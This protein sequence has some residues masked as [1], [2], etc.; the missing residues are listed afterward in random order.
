MRLQAQF[1]EATS[2]QRPFLDA[3]LRQ[4]PVLDA[5]LR[6]RSVL[7]VTSRQR[8]S[9]MPPRDCRPCSSQLPGPFRSL[10]TPLAATSISGGHFHQR[11]PPTGHMIRPPPL[12]TESQHPGRDLPS[13]HFIRWWSTYIYLCLFDPKYKSDVS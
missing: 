5:T 9:W 11:W 12:H 2:R 7:D 10:A 1:L 8:P 4:R 6:Q 13:Q 3:T